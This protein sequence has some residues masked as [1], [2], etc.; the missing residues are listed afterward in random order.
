MATPPFKVKALYDYNS[1][2]PDDLNFPHGQ[3][4]T[5]TE[6][7]DADWYQGEFV[8]ST[9]SK[10]EGI[11]PMNFVERFEPETPPRPVRSSRP[12]KTSD[13]PSQPMQ[14][15]ESHER[16]APEA[17]QLAR[18]PRVD[19]DGTLQSP[20]G[21]AAS[22]PDRP[23]DS[24][25][26][27]A[28]V[29]VA[30]PHE[31]AQEDTEPPKQTQQD[32]SRNKAPPP[33][34]EKPAGGSFRDRIAAFNK[35]AAPPVAPFKPGGL[36]SSTGGG[37]IKK[38]FVAPPPSRNAYVPPPR[39]VPAA[40][41]YRRED[42]PDMRTDEDEGPRDRPELD[43]QPSQAEADDESGHK[44]T[45]LKERIALLQKQQQEQATRHAEAASKKEKPKKP[46]KRP[47]EALGDLGETGEGSEADVQAPG[48]VDDGFNDRAEVINAAR[49]AR[50]KATN[51]A[52]RNARS[53][54]DRLRD[55]Q[56]DA[57]DADQS[58]AGDTTEDAGETSP[59][60]DDS[61]DKMKPKQP[62]RPTEMR[63]D[64]EDEEEVTEGGDD[65]HEED[66]D[67]A[68]DVDPE[69]KRRLEIRERMAK[70]SGGMGM[71]GMF[72]PAAGLPPMGTAAPKTQRQNSTKNR[73][74]EQEG[75][76]APESTATPRAPP[77][78]ILPIPAKQPASPPAEGGVADAES[79]DDDGGSEVR[80]DLAR[81]S[82]PGAHLAPPERRQAPPAPSDARPVPQ[83]PVPSERGL[84]P[85]IPGQRP[86]PPPTP[87][88]R[89]VP[90]PPPSAAPLSPSAGSE[91]DDEMS[92]H[93][94]SRAPTAPSRQTGRAEQPQGTSLIPSAEAPAIPE[95]AGPTS[96]QSPSVR[97]AATVRT[98]EASVEATP[99]EGSKKLS[100]VAKDPDQF[101]NTSSPTSPRPPPP[102]PPTAAPP[103]RLLSR[104]STGDGRA[105]QPRTMTIR[106]DSEEEVTEY[107]G[108]YDTDIAPG[109]DHKDALKSRPAEAA[110]DGESTVDSTPVR[111][112]K[113]TPSA[114]SPPVP[115]VVAPRGVAPPPPPQ[116]AGRPSAEMPRAAPPPVPPP[117][118]T[119]PET[120]EV[121]YDPYRYSA[122]PGR[123]PAAP[124]A[125]R[126]QPASYEPY[127]EPHQRESSM[128]REPPVTA[129]QTSE[130]PKPR[131]TNSTSTP[132]SLD[133]SRVSEGGR[134]STDQ[135]R[136]SQ[137]LPRRS[138]EQ[139][140]PSGDSGH[141]AMD[142]EMDLSSRWWAQPNMPPPVF[143]NR[144]DLIYE[145]EETSTSKRGGKTTISRDV[146]VLFSDYSQTVVTAQF[147]S[148]D[149]DDVHI[150]QRHEPPPPRLRQDQLEEA[151]ARFGQQISTAVQARQNAVVGDGSPLSLIYELLRP[152]ADALM[153]VGSRSF[154]ALIYT[155]LANASVQQFDE[156][157]AGDI[158]TLRS[159]KFQ[160]HRGPV[161]TKYT[162]EVGKPDHVGV[163]LDW[164]GTKK[165]VRAWEQGRESKKV[166]LES[167][168]LG[169]L[170][171]GEVKIWRVVSRKWVG[172]EGQN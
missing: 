81:N 156:I 84:P 106:Q 4:I 33:V 74:R 12:K 86:I 135:G 107:E 52:S 115:P 63:A 45:S 89:P 69:V 141:M 60:L 153:P 2:E 51:E 70:M 5:V 138:V 99:G 87:G 130:L 121:E 114:S 132:R 101:T 21:A 3:I 96:P 65:D 50:H 78:P 155:N 129:G 13:A 34:S 80:M 152:L 23:Q 103:S 6:E 47:T 116:R 14:S 146:Y 170:K 40:K 117:R 143:Q 91:S 61:D 142:V 111:S 53:S 43:T 126:S 139:G 42:D 15:H 58:G 68:T 30:A 62:I 97:S 147:D 36:G 20:Q 151:H 113:A 75:Q 29:P 162:V 150:E 122:P 10:R 124:V 168:K 48:G 95:R 38:P 145:V 37:F 93:T 167:F 26:T 109:A 72:G 82:P 127:P 94:S 108:D 112:P 90:P 172:W 16:Q 118:A 164:D 28:P 67:E 140:R 161:H 32:P 17:E 71:P 46:S 100:R 25:S 44:P 119:S 1:Q 19:D 171:S 148:K 158:I 128:D 55:S 154:G 131:P 35:P 56:S 165:K 39:E 92:L 83:P 79:F 144:G 159:A 160:G 105:T 41:P 123:A 125:M 136:V 104:T 31:S 102:P 7:E 110:D 85:P 157:R 9:G 149:M 49:A 59:G 8:D 137:T 27:S 66:G 11:F 22:A 73:E 169:D 18:G 64:D 133:V 76:A 88:A 163:I 77:V 166:K 24:T 134:K 98:G 54:A 120:E 57:N